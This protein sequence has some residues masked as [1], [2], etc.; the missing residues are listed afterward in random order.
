M[1]RVLSEYIKDYEHIVLVGH[2]GGGT[3]ATLLACEQATSY[4]KSTTL[5]T[6][7][8]NLDTD[9]WTDHHGWSRMAGSLNPSRFLKECPRL[10]QY[11]YVGREDIN[12]PYT[13]NSNFF[14]QQSVTPIIYEDANHSNWLNFWP[15]IIRSNPDIH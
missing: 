6:L 10:N 11:H 3:I 7:S 8:A 4:L 12:V 13:L 14:K 1:Q 9:K 15:E 2:S 5:I